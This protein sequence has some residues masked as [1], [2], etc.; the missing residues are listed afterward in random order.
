MLPA[1][2]TVKCDLRPRRLQGVDRRPIQSIHNSFEPK[3]TDL[4]SE[5]KELFASLRSGVH[6]G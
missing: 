5:M 3:T 4:G 2:A 1:I 6:L